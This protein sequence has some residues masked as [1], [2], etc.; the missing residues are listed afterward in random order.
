M[1]K[2]MMT[3]IFAIL[4]FV[5][6][7]G[8]NQQSDSPPSKP[9][10]SKETSIPTKR[11][12]RTGPQKPPASDSIRKKNTPKPTKEED[13]PLQLNDD[14]KR[15]EHEEKLQLYFEK[16]E[17]INEPTPEQLITLGELAFDAN[18]PESAY[19]HFLEIIEENP[20]D[21]MAPFALYKFA[22]VE[23]NLGDVD[24]AILDMELVTEWIEM[25]DVQQEGILIRAA[26]E[27]LLFF[28]K[29]KTSSD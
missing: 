26:P 28:K 14:A 18:D 1:N 7:W 11:K 19:E 10:I 17:S 5:V 16:L 25:G 2:T 24:A 4:V 29:S 6:I 8:R 12:M 13:L 20:D 22:W 9:H 15:K 27:D 23:F 21:K 3:T